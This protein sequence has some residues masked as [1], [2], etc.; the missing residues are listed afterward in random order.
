MAFSPVSFLLGVGTACLLPVVS[1]NFRPIAVEGMAM[2]LGVLEDLRRVMAEQLENLE[3]IAA[4]ARA[5]REQL[6]GA[7]ADLDVDTGEDEA[8]HDGNGARH[9]APAGRARQRGAARSRTRAT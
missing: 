2:G 1:R 8:T 5:R 9:P 3:D 6:A 4:E 7:A